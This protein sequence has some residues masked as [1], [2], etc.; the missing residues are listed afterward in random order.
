MKSVAE[1]TQQYIEK[2]KVSN[3]EIIVDFLNIFQIKKTKKVIS[4]LSKVAP[5]LKKYL[6]YENRN[7]L[8]LV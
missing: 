3:E 1:L 2:T 4:E 8:F 5:D 7:K 6:K